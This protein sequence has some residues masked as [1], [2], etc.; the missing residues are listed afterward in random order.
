MGENMYSETAIKNLTEFTSRY[1]MEALELRKRLFLFEFQNE[2]AK[3]HATS[4]AARRLGTLATSIAMVFDSIA[5]NLEK[6]PD[7]N[8]IETATIG[9]QHFVGNAY[10]FLDNI[11]H[12][13]NSEIMPVN[14]DGE[15]FPR[16]YIG[17]L[18]SN[19]SFRRV[20]PNEFKKKLSQH[21]G[22]LEE[23]KEIR[24]H[25]GHGLPLYIVPFF[26]TPE[27]GKRY[28][29]LEDKKWEATFAGDLELSESLSE[30]Q[31]ALGRFMPVA[32]HDLRVSRPY[33]FHALIQALF[34]ALIIL[35]NELLSEIE[36]RQQAV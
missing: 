10:G 20:L 36:S 22:L 32:S 5:P 14:K 13:W 29:E 31:K 28:Q 23:A 26:L 1:G 35:G 9:V 3:I 6:Q 12:I 17:L 11:A 4:G 18:K 25:L 7:E 2:E 19:K 34:D 24:D 30:Q 21:N 16:K 27:E 8:S 15:P 33:Y